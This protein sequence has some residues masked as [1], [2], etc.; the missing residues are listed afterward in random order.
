[1]PSRYSDNAMSRVSLEDDG[2]KTKKLYLNST[3]TIKTI[4]V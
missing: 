4:D 3:P 2:F 1:M